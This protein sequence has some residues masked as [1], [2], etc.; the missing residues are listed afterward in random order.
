MNVYVI[1]MRI[2][3][4]SVTQKK[5]N[6]EE[7]QVESRQGQKLNSPYSFLKKTSQEF[8]SLPKMVLTSL[9]PHIFG[10]RDQ[11][12]SSWFLR[13]V[14]TIFQSVRIM[15]INSNRGRSPKPFIIN[16]FILGNYLLPI[17]RRFIE[18]KGRKGY[19]TFGRQRNVVLFLHW[20]GVVSFN[21]CSDF[22]FRETWNLDYQIPRW[23]I[24]DKINT[25]N[26]FPL[27]DIDQ[28]LLQWFK[29]HLQVTV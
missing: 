9:V 5:T 15:L 17:K 23:R 27:L 13:F 26:N 7:S 24:Y 14:A 2:Q 6:C 20:L 25:V 18:V 16:F 8:L 11:L 19:K 1:E 3:S 28:K 4:F 12:F 22:E 10:H 21:I 29:M